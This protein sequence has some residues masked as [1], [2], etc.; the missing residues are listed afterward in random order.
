M[1]SHQIRSS[2][3][4]RR[5]CSF[6]LSG[7][8]Q[9]L[10][11]PVIAVRPQSAE[12]RGFCNSCI[13]RNCG[14]I[15]K[16]F[17]LH[18]DNTSLK[19]TCRFT[20]PANPENGHVCTCQLPKNPSC[21]P[22]KE[23]KTRSNNIE[24]SAPF[25]RL[26]GNAHPDD[27][28]WSRG[29]RTANQKRFC[30]GGPKPETKDLLTAICSAI[31]GDEQQVAN[32]LQ[33]TWVE[34]W[35]GWE[36]I[37]KN[38]TDIVAMAAAEDFLRIAKAN[39]PVQMT[40]NRR[41]LQELHD[42]GL[43]LQTASPNGNNCLIDSILLG[44]MAAGVAPKQYTVTERKT[45]CKQCRDELHSQ[46]GT[47]VGPFLDGHRDAPRI[48]NYFLCRLWQADISVRVQFYDRL[49]KEELGDAADEVTFL[50]FT[51]GQRLL[52][53]R[54]F[55]HIF[56]HLDEYGRGYHF[57]A[58]C[59]S[60]GDSS[61]SQCSGKRKQD[62]DMEK[63]NSA[64][65]TREFSSFKRKHFADML[66]DTT[67]GHPATPARPNSSAAWQSHDNVGPASEQPLPQHPR[68][69]ASDVERIREN[70]FNTDELALQLHVATGWR[71]V[72]G[73]RPA[74]GPSSS[75]WVP[76]LL[77]G[78]LRAGT[79]SDATRSTPPASTAPRPQK[80][81]KTTD[82]TRTAPPAT[83]PSLPTTKRLRGKQ[84][85]PAEP[86]AS[87]VPA[88]A[89]EVVLEQDEYILGAWLAIHGN[90]D[91]RAE[92]EQQI[93]TLATRFRLRPLLPDKL[94]ALCPKELAYDLPDFCCAFQGCSFESSDVA[95]FHQHLRMEHS[96]DL[97]RV[98][99]ALPEPLQGE[100]VLEA[101]RMVLSWACQ[102]GAPTAHVAIDRKCLRQLREAQKADRVGAAICFLC[103]QRYPYTHGMTEADEIQWHIGS[104][105]QTQQ[106]F[107]LCRFPMHESISAKRRIGT[108][109]ANATRP[110]HDAALNAN[111]Q[112]GA[113]RC[114]WTR[115]L[116]VWFVARKTKT[117][118][119]DVPPKRVASNAVLRSASAVGRACFGINAPNRKC[120]QTICSYFIL[121]TRS[122]ETKSPSWNLSAPALASPQ[123][124]VLASKKNCWVTAP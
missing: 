6:S 119:P 111:W 68:L 100:P 98:I 41:R 42:Q 74:C 48:L 25:T 66:P 123:W 84:S 50:D 70:W 52:Y 45:L 122:T 65:D 102:Q 73:F 117:V 116:F 93:A 108:H 63:N 5:Y 109:T 112:T 54:R 11:G 21:W 76:R 80:R 82:E 69:S 3:R 58:L 64:V 43:R 24:K 38:K 40:S 83:G 37:E 9:A 32:M 13:T 53:E 94:Q 62:T 29:S 88:A 113:P 79:G 28:Y 103:A 39:V 4:R 17:L 95:S 71:H 106:T 120:W 51:S 47:P 35:A 104:S 10:P 89:A 31:V 72:R 121:Q 14:S 75:Q 33:Q 1:P 114:R 110:T 57:D 19:S 55:L 86:V 56:T 12:L 2:Q 107:W 97:H 49:S 85:V 8:D 96:Q 124:L 44:L 90:H 77:C 26:A 30:G 67:P 115:N 61:F 60:A 78:R 101:Y 81:Q 91:P 27:G 16:T 7:M 46:Y 36:E 15:L 18:S 118:Q 105:A 87:H 34:T 99:Y 59:P 20:L 22:T 92:A 23:R